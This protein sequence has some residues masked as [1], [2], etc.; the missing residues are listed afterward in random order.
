MNLIIPSSLYLTLSLS[1]T[2]S[3]SVSFSS[4][5]FV[6]L[7]LSFLLFLYQFVYLFIWHHLHFVLLLLSVSHC[8]F[9]FTC[10]VNLSVFE[11]LLFI[12]FLSS[13]FFI[14]C[15]KHGHV[16]VCLF[17]LFHLCVWLWDKYEAAVGYHSVDWFQ[18]NSCPNMLE[19]HQRLKRPAYKSFNSTKK[20]NSRTRFYTL[21][22]A[23]S[24]HCYT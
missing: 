17:S 22:V 12:F 19:G 4:C 18:L 20:G 9:I 21:D 13:N 23:F 11:F 24:H 7:Y 8:L 16:F 10:H 5:P 15:L 3:F 6:S 14:F 2:H 1:F